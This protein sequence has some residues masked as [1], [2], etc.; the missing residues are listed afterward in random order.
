MFVEK[1]DQDYKVVSIFSV[2]KEKL[3]LFENVSY[4][5]RP[6]GFINCDKQLRWYI[7]IN[8]IRFDWKFGGCSHQ[9]LASFIVKVKHGRVD[10]LKITISKFNLPCP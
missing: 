10:K 8:F 5:F 7:E 2:L 9:I 4:L 1:V 3:I 6:E